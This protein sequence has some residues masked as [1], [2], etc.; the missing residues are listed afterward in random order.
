[1]DATSAKTDGAKMRDLM[2][3]AVKRQH[4]AKNG[5]PFYQKAGNKGKAKLGKPSKH[6]YNP[7]NEFNHGNTFDTYRYV[8]DIVNTLTVLM[9]F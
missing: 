4:Y 3:Q 9:I 7:S 6:N 5:K 1:M 2:K 8:N